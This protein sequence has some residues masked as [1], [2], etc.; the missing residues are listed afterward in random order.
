MKFLT[1]MHGAQRMVHRAAVAVTLRR[2]LH[3][4]SALLRIALYPGP[5]TPCPSL[6]LC[7]TP[8]AHLRRQFNDK[9]GALRQVILHADKAVV[10]GNNRADNCQS[11]PHAGFFS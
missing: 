8:S 7:P 3:R 10:I 1:S 2:P 9:F 6:T 11:Q 4:P 5:A